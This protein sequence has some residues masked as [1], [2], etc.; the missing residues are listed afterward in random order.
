[1]EKSLF[2]ICLPG[3]YASNQKFTAASVAPSSFSPNWNTLKRQKVQQ[4]LHR[5]GRECDG[6]FVAHLEKTNAFWYKQ[7]WRLPAVGKLHLLLRSWTGSV[8]DREE[9]LVNQTVY[10]HNN[11]I[12]RGG[13]RWEEEDSLSFRTRLPGLCEQPSKQFPSP[14]KPAQNTHKCSRWNPAQ[15]GWLMRL[16]KPGGS[17]YLLINATSRK[18]L[19]I[20]GAL[21]TY[22]DQ[23]WR[24]EV[25]TLSYFWKIW[26][27]LI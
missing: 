14:W 21:I 19:L 15:Q 12:T 7:W 11:D 17:F 6:I 18:V 5:S 9:T 1:M 13:M 23:L 10:D 27:S 24:Y 22:A 26:P 4:M 8:V 25:S 3:I 20:V 16:W 2:S